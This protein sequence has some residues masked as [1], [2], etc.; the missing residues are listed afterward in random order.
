MDITGIST[1]FSARLPMW[2]L[3]ELA[4]QPDRL[5]SDAER[6]VLVHRLAARNYREGGG[7]P[8]AALAVDSAPPVSWSRPGSTWCWTPG[9]R[10]CTPRWWP[11]RW[12]SSAGGTWDLG[13][14]DAAALEL[15][16]NW[17]PCAMCYG[18][19]LRSGVRRLVIAGDGPEL[20][21][22]T[23]FDEGPVREDW[24]E[25]LAKRGITV[26]PDVLRDEALAVFA[27]FGEYVA[28]SDAVVYN[29][30]GQEA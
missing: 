10:R 28:A 29:A 5:G 12:P 18:A 22:L 6:M 15:V 2:V 8:F 3:T 19:V 17:R 25:Q 23:G 1:R 21:Q 24:A 20:E 30:R 11:S 13:N 4:A 16:V 26:P 14:V 7:G 9:C 27:E